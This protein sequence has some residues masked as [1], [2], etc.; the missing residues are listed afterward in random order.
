MAYVDSHYLAVHCYD[1]HDCMQSD[2]S[3]GSEAVRSRNVADHGNSS[4]DIRGFLFPEAAKLLRDCWSA[5]SDD[6]PSLN[7]IL[8]RGE[9]MNSKLTANVKSSK[10]LGDCQLGC[11]QPTNSHR[12]SVPGVHVDETNADFVPPIMFRVHR[13]FSFALKPVRHALTGS[14]PIQMRRW[15]FR[16]QIRRLKRDRRMM[17]PLPNASDEQPRKLDGQHKHGHISRL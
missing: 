11:V 15:A 12:S 3:E 5:D 4:P 6:R 9:R 7:H 10:L 1:N 2:I 14:N 8:Q 13:Q 16:L 17:Q